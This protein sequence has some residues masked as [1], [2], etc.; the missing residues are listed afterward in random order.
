MYNVEVT[1]APL[2]TREMRFCHDYET[3]L[4][5]GLG[6]LQLKTFNYRQISQIA[7]RNYNFS[8]RIQ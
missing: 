2:E 7:L 5:R 4:V 3:K 8:K 1:Y 6:E